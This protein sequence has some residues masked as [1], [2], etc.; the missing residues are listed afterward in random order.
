MCGGRAADLWRWVSTALHSISCLIYEF[1][2]CTKFSEGVRWYIFPTIGNSGFSSQSPMRSTFNT[3][4]LSRTINNGKDAEP[5]LFMTEL[6]IF[7]CEGFS[8]FGPL[9]AMYGYAVGS[10]QLRLVDQL[11]GTLK[12]CVQKTY[13]SWRW[14]A[15]EAQYYERTVREDNSNMWLEYF[16][17][18]M[19][20]FVRQS[21]P[22][23]MLR[24]QANTTCLHLSNV[25]SL[26]QNRFGYY[27]LIM[28]MMHS[29]PYTIL[30]KT[31][32]YRRH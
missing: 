2:S 8:R 5:S 25:L 4:G 15:D 3:Q 13:P 32:L 20:N 27:W 17:D 9:C 21:S 24:S 14:R 19:L 18:Q 6:S 29:A 31:D 11:L 12:S 28:M 7:P 10:V 26:F 1:I 23:K 22:L 30:P 16:W